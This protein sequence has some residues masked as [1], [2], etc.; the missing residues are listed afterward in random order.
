MN[1]GC[2]SGEGCH[3]FSLASRGDQRNLLIRIIP[4]L[5]NLDQ[6][7]VRDL[8]IPQLRG[9]ADNVYHAPALHSH[10]PAVLVCRIDDLLHPVHIGGKGRDNDPGIL[11][12]CKYIV[13]GLSNRA[14][15][16]GKSLALRIGTVTHQCQY[17][18][19]SDFRKPLQVNGISE[20]RSIVHFKVT[21][22]HHDSRRGID[23]QCGR[24]L[25]AVV[26][27]D[28]F[29]T[30]AAQINGLSMFDHFSLGTSEQIVL[31]KFIFD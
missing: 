10:L 15:R 29:Y 28:K 21:G 23:R 6:S 20:Y 26:C 11:V 2:H 3:G 22:V 16:H 19:L 9:R 25:D 17:T 8:Q 5:V 30:K 1:A 31:F 27:L 4:K 18:L 7:L 13:K 14:L 12:L 24:I